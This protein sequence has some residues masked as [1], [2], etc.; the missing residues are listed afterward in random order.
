[1]LITNQTA[2]EAPPGFLNCHLLSE[3]FFNLLGLI[4]FAAV[5]KW[6]GLK[7]TKSLFANHA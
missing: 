4:H 5:D 1:M 7:V 6:H 3:V 2:L